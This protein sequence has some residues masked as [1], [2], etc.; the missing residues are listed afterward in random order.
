MSTTL[1]E[2]QKRPASFH[3]RNGGICEYVSPTRLNLWLRCPLAFRLRYVDGIRTPT[4]PALFLGKAVHA[5]LAFWYEARLSATEAESRDVQRQLAREWDRLIEAEDMEFTSAKD[6]DVL[7]DQA[8]ALVS[9]YL[10][11][12]PSNE[13]KPIAV[14]TCLKAPLIDPDN[15]ENLG[16]PLLGIIDL[17]L[18]DPAGPIIADFKTASRG[19]TPI[20]VVHELQLSC[21]AYL[22]RFTSQERESAVEIRNLIKTK[23]PK[24]EFHRWPARNP[25]YFGRLFSVLRAYLDS[26]NAGRFVYRP[27][28]TCSS[29]DFCHKQC[30]AWRG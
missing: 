21:Y 27:S 2:Q 24:I 14:E 28:W 5:A 8:W 26:L 18:D 13:P 29:C 10:D 20:E 16:I 23:T 7:K 4:T 22:Y 12:L 19:G 9:T 30:R 17:V 3:H 15:G 11:N 1:V 25:A 6:E